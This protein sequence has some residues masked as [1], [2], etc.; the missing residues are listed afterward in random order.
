MQS[1]S[2]NKMS[3]LNLLGFT[4]KKQSKFYISTQLNLVE[5]SLVEIKV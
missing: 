3:W 4:V 2:S 1:L 5:L